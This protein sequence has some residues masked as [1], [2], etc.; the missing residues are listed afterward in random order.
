M[1][2]NC[3]IP[4]ADTSRI[5]EAICI[6][7]KRIYDSC[8]S[9]D[10]LENLRVTFHSRSQELIDNAV[11]VKCK[12][13][14]IVTTVIDVQEVPFN[15]GFYSVDISYFFKLKFD[16]FK[17]P[18][19]VPETT[20]GFAKFSKKCI[21]YG[22]EGDVKVFSSSCEQGCME[23]NDAAQY[24]NPNAKVQLVDPVVLSC[25]VVE[26]CQCRIPCCCCFPR[27]VTSLIDDTL[28]T[29]CGK[30]AVLV[31]LGLFSIVQIERDVQVLVP[32]YD[33]CVPNHECCCDNDNPC[34]TFSKINFPMDEF[35]PKD[36]S[37][38]CCKPT[39]GA[40]EKLENLAN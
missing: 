6:D 24:C 17:C 29:N 37:N 27:S 28:A 2:D 7:T 25:D 13:C 16:T 40:C 9:K 39:H 12:D 3:I 36:K 31:T 30:K 1:A 15:H 34:D 11:L 32:A 18:T 8:V 21:L 19:A 14:E 26:L 5:R 22:G 23:E 4:N 33:Y 38:D 35:F 10:C 20:I